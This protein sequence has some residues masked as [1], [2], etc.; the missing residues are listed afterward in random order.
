[1]D[2]F[3]SQDSVNNAIAE[4]LKTLRR[5]RRLSL[6]NVSEL[7]GV[8]KSM[9]GQIE[10]SESSPTISTLWKIATG[11]HI[12][13][14]SLME[15]PTEETTVIKN[16]DIKPLLSDNDHFKLYPIFPKDEIRSFEMF[17]IE[18]DPGTCSVSLPHAPGTEEFVIIY[19]GILEL[20]LGDSDVYTVPKG[21][22]ITYK[23]DRNHTYHNPSNETTKLCMV[24]NYK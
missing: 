8:S 14:S 5:Q 3:E 6:D 2:Q 7:T 4:N 9:L 24:I 22:S 17:Y 15:K 19:D 13:F 10:R 23:A 11:L 16:S 20:T 1:M 18:M 12:S 21:S